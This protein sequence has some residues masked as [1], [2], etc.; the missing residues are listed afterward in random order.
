MKIICFKKDQNKI[1]LLIDENMTMDRME[2]IFEDEFVKN[3]NTSKYNRLFEVLIEENKK[4]RKKNFYGQYIIAV[5][6]L[7]TGN[8]V[9][10]FQLIYY[11]TKLFKQQ[12]H[13]EKWLGENFNQGVDFFNRS[14]ICLKILFIRHSNNN[15]M[16]AAEQYAYNIGLIAGKYVKYREQEE[17][18]PKSLRDILTY[19][20]Y[21]R[22]KLRYVYCKICLGVNLS[23][24][25]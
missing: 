18:S 22:D 6:S 16:D 13:K 1:D 25:R 19:T 21:D 7:I 5:R 24:L 4:N 17:K 2:K 23:N 15:F 11:L 12:I 14:W 8:S 3:V 10:K 9:E 20:K